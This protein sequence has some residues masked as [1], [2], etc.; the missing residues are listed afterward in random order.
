MPFYFS[1]LLPNNC[2]KNFECARGHSTP[3]HALRGS[4]LE[5]EILGRASCLFL[6]ALLPFFSGTPGN[7]GNRESPLCCVSGEKTLCHLRFRRVYRGC[8]VE[9]SLLFSPSGCI[10]L[11]ARSR[12]SATRPGVLGSKLLQHPEI[13]HSCRVPAGEQWP[14][15]PIPR[16]VFNGR[17]LAV[18]KR[19][20]FVADGVT[21]KRR[22]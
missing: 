18:S 9:G 6:Y 20:Y 3:A 12:D 15:R 7:L 21:G 22:S 2:Q 1:L 11:A 5:Y 17:R 16:R 19:R 4:T 13:S 14:G 10:I 8:A